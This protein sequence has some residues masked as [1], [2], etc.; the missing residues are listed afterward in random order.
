MNREAKVYRLR[1]GWKPS[2][3]RALSSR[4][5]V[6]LEYHGI[7]RKG[8]EEDIAN[9]EFEK[10]IIFLKH[11]YEIV[12]PNRILEK[13]KLLDR[14]QVMLTFDDGFRN[15]AEVVAPIL[16][17]HEVPA[18]FFVCS[19][20]SIP[21]KYLWFNYLRALEKHFPGNGF[22]FCGEFIN[23]SSGQRHISI[24]RLEKYLLAL[25]PH[26]LAMYKVIDKE[27][28][29]LEDFV[30]SATLDDSFAGMTSEQVGELAADSLFTIGNHTLDHPFLTRCGPEE[31]ARQILQNKIWIEDVSNRKCDDIAYPI[32][33]YNLDV[34]NQ[35]RRLNVTHGFVE[36]A[37][38]GSAPHFEIP[39]VGIY[40]KSLDVL[41]F[42]VHWGNAYMKMVDHRRFKLSSL[43]PMRV[44]NTH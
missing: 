30:A 10:H 15:H 9:A 14:I 35:C 27:L 4:K 6:I 12:E 3:L 18:M 44:P 43:S 20:H 31:V 37:L 28:P 17:K 33:D 32:G 34:M 11:H 13:R 29:R 19:R 38:F 22:H 8:Y 21:G 23:M 26:P 42:K 36:T 5:P 1:I 39:R 2:Y 16:R 24:Q 40:S 41:A 7:P 25:T